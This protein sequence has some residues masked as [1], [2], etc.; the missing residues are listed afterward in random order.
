MLGT[1][2]G[3][4]LVKRPRKWITLHSPR[5]MTWLWRNRTVWRNTYGRRR[6]FAVHG[7]CCI[8]C[9]NGSL[10]EARPDKLIERIIWSYFN[11]WIMRGSGAIHYKS[12]G[13]RYLCIFSASVL[14][15]EALTFCIDKIIKSVAFFSHAH[16]CNI[17][18]C[19]CNIRKCYMN[20]WCVSAN[21][22]G[23]TDFRFNAVITILR[24]MW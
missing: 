13:W 15:K 24:F 6:H 14:L 19:N 18:P 5:I 4:G 23:F 17:V 16:P 1:I 21:T 7:Y 2:S 20:T 10:I 8:H 9:C 11:A 3:H 22:M 12:P